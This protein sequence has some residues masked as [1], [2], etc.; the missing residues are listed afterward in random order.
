[1]APPIA[2]IYRLMIIGALDTLH[3]ANSL[4]I[5]GF[6]GKSPQEKQKGGWNGCHPLEP[7]CG[8]QERELAW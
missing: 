5:R 2:A 3:L 6:Q 7:D 8:A 1:M 4:L